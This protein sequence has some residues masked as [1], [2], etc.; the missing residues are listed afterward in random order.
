MRTV[1][2]I[3]VLSLAQLGP[4]DLSPPGPEPPPETQTLSTPPV[5]TPPPSAPPVTPPSPPVE[6][7]PTPPPV[8]TEPAVIPDQEA[9]KQT[10]TYVFSEEETTYVWTHYCDGQTPP[11]AEDPF[12]LPDFQ[13][14]LLSY[15][16]WRSYRHLALFYLPLHLLPQKIEKV[17]LELFC[18]QDGGE[19]MDTDVY[20]INEPWTWPRQDEPWQAIC[21]DSFPDSSWTDGVWYGN[22]TPHT[23]QWF[24]IDITDTYESWTEE[25]WS[26]PKPNYGFAITSDTWHTW[27]EFYSSRYGANPEL[28][29]RIIMEYYPPVPRRLVFPLGGKYSPDRVSGY[30]FGD[31]WKGQNCLNLNVHLLH[32]GTDFTASPGHRVSAAATGKVKLERTDAKE[33]GFVVL[34]CRDKDERGDDFFYTFTYTHVTPSANL[35]LGRWVTQGEPIGT[36]SDIPSA[37]LHLQVRMASYDDRWSIIGRLPEIGCTT[38]HSPNEAE[39]TFPEKFFDPEYLDWE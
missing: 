29:P 7:T 13:T 8:F 39:P 30:R 5:T 33:G 38:S 4:C 27:A 18:S 9:E 15:G 35:V 3:A 23:N 20:R 1:L 2:L 11:P 21:G 6:P 19:K 36:V 34:E 24:P 17:S 28:R 22:N 31:W 14:L 26:D 32:T 37:N 16:E 10:R 25:S 12:G